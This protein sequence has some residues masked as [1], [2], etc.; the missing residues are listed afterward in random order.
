MT[1]F[2]RCASLTLLVLSIACRGT[3]D[4]S[5]PTVGARPSDSAKMSSSAD[6]KDK[7]IGVVL[8]SVYD[9]FA[10]ST[11]P[12]ATVLHF[13]SQSDLQLAVLAGKVDAG[14]S[15]EQPILE[16][17]RTNGDLALFGEPL[18]T[19]PL[20]VGFR[21]GN[22]EL[23]DGFNRFLAGIKQS[24]VHAD[25]IDR[26]LRNHET[27]MPAIPALQR[28]GGVL[29]VGVSSGGLPFGGVQD[30]IYVGFDIELVE[31]FAAARGLEIKFSQMPFGALIAA[32]ASGKADMIAASIFI[33]DER[34]QRIDFSDPYFETT[35]RAYAL[36]ANIAEAGT[37]ASAGTM[38]Q[39]G[40]AA[41]GHAPSFAARIASSFRSN[42]IAERRYLL[43]WDGFKATVLISL[44][45]T[46]FGTALGALVCFMRMSPLALLRGAASL[47]IAVLR[48]TPIV[49]LLMI[50]FY[51]V[52]GSVDISP[53][54]VA[55]IAFGMNF[56]AYVSEMFRA[57]IE[58]IDKGQ[59]EAGI[60]MGFTPKQT[61]VHIIFPQMVQRI[62]PVFK[63]EFIS[64]VK[65]TSVVGYIAV[66]D[67]T[68]ASDIIRSRTFDAFFPLIMVAVLY[69]FIAWGLIQGLEYLERRT[70]P[71]LAGKRAAAR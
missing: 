60:A 49:V 25:M 44:F 54:V 70:N 31:R 27:Q 59:G 3:E 36:R 19:L 17:L 6:L 33:T 23:R 48:G 18:L 42:I 9:R 45:A 15:D 58:S 37:R 16:V 28:P 8:G 71:K 13:E 47:Y 5:A 62:L 1:T 57:G 52:F 35:G 24:G 22:T 21:K 34:K 65:M 43:L 69:F 64:L 26:W 51:V 41:A 68:K 30:G 46:I 11:Y 50:I 29:V 40:A 63:G 10:T 38:A 66:Q 53:I 14:L 2:V 61:F 12:Q 4:R 56:A 55:I 7:R 32:N 39:P 67:L 20:G